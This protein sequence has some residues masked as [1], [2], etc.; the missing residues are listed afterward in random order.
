M[1][2]KEYPLFL[3][4][5]IGIICFVIWK[6]S[7]ISLSHE[8]PADY[9]IMPHPTAN[10]IKERIVYFIFSFLFAICFY[11]PFY[12][13]RKYSN[14]KI[15]IGA[16]CVIVF[17][18]ILTDQIS[19]NTKGLLL[20]NWFGDDYGFGK[21]MIKL[22][23]LSPILF[24]IFNKL[25]FFDFP[26][27]NLIYLFLMNF[28]VYFLAKLISH[29]GLDGIVS[30]IRDILVDGYFIIFYALAFGLISISANK[31]GLSQANKSYIDDDE[32]LD[33]DFNRNT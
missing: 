27:R 1:K 30:T 8:M 16:I 13:S 14:L 22:F 32:I 6:F 5:L 11:Y 25:V 20:S 31:K 23:F 2:A 33:S 19:S 18:F 29:P 12:L 4:G 28:A 3:A 7:G 21:N 17:L 15:S 26:N 10:T 24:F 9:S